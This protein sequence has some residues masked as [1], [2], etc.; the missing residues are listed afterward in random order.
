MTAYVFY[1]GE[2][3]I[4]PDLPPTDAYTLGTWVCLI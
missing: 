4:H 3:E 2:V 1:M